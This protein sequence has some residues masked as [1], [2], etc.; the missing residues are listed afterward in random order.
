[1][2]FNIISNFASS[3]VF[4]LLTPL[5]AVCVLP[6]YPGFL[7]YL[8]NQI[9]KQ[10]NKK[11]AMI[12]FGLLITLGAVVFMALL[13]IVFTMFL[14]KSLTNVIG[15]VSPIAFSFLALLSIFLILDIDVGKFIPKARVPQAKNPFLSAFFYG[16]FFGAIVVPCNPLF[17]AAL[18]TR[19]LGV[20]DLIVNLGNFLFFGLG[21]GAPLLVLALVGSASRPFI[22]FLTQHKKII[23]RVAGLIML[24]ISVYYLVFIF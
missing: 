8:A 21:I 7:A 1:M 4:G 9:E 13:G 22:N 15:V 11:R 3:F 19:G 10:E 23:N 18:F 24:V 6:L 17:I 12:C 2:I 16:F 5:S 20:S 14:Q